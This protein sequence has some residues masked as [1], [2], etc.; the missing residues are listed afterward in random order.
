MPSDPAPI[1]LTERVNAARRP[2]WSAYL[3]KI[4]PPSG[5]TRNPTAKMPA[6]FNSCAV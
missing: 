6:V 1:R 3:P 2:N 4:Q 5:R